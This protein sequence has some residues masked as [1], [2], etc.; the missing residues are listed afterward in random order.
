M[1]KMCI[2]SYDSIKIV[3]GFC[4]SGST[5]RATLDYFSGRL[6]LGESRLYAGVIAGGA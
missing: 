2:I 6:K 1:I 4:G 3:R 5:T